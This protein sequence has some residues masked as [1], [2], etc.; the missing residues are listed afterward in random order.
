MVS[1]GVGRKL[2]LGLNKLQEIPDEI[3]CLSE[4]QELMCS[5]NHIVMVS[6][7]IQALTHL[8]ALALASNRLESLPTAEL[9]SLPLLEHMTIHNNPISKNSVIAPLRSRRELLEFLDSINK[10][11]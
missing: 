3:K 2:H 10:Q 8:R 7:A 6:P 9:E 4:L 5:N 1:H 11:N